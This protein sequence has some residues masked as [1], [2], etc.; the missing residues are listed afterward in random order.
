MGTYGP[1]QLRACRPGADEHNGAGGVLFRVRAARVGEHPLVVRA[2]GTSL[3]DAL[4]RTVRV[5][6]AGVDRPFTFSDRLRGGDVVTQTITIP[7]DSTDN[8][9]DCS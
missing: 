5:V 2:V 7:A 9:S 4:V 6:P 8:A 1:V 3:S